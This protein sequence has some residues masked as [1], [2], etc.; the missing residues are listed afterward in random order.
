MIDLTHG[1][2]VTFLKSEIQAV[3]AKNPRFRK[4]FGEVQHAFG[5][6]IHFSQGDVRVVVTNVSGSGTRLSMDYYL[7]TQYG[8]VCA[9]KLEG[10]EGAFIEWTKEVSTDGTNMVPGMNYLNIA[11]VDEAT[12]EVVMDYQFMRWVEYKAPDPAHGT[13]FYVKPPWKVENIGIDGLILGTDYYHLLN[14]MALLTYP[15]GPLRLYD[16]KTNDTLIPGLDWFVMRDDK[17]KL[18]DTLGGKQ[19]IILPPEVLSLTGLEDQDGYLL[20]ERSDYWRDGGGIDLTDY[21]PVGHEIWGVGTFIFDPNTTDIIHPENQIKAIPNGHETLVQKELV[22]KMGD[23]PHGFSDIHVRADG[24]YWFKFLADQGDWIFWEARFQEALTELKA[25]K[26]TV[27]QNMI[28]GVQVAIGDQVVVG[29]QAVVIVFPGVEE[30]YEIYGSKESLT[31]DLEV[32]S[33]DLMT[34]S[35]LAG[36]IRNMLL[37]QNR[38]RFES[39]GLTI[40]EVSRSYRGEQ[41][42]ISGTVSKHVVTLGVTAAADWEL[43]F[44]LVTRVDEIGLEGVQMAHTFP[45]KPLVAPRMQA[46]GVTRFTQ[47]H[48]PAY[49]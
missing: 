39:A 29:D 23:G 12:G 13:L 31:F 30:T 25:T 4:N 47:D 42:D 44:P 8:R 27:N 3:V 48:A 28:P 1:N 9:A 26:M 19:H 32:H 16:T 5:N 20:R 41:K 15:D 18:A 33:N 45:G 21:T 34:S 24:T 37:I 36:L 43:Q 10:K 46:F 11:S 7:C 6:T 2:L 35:E 49:Y 38:D 40:Y 14:G 22:Y 17:L